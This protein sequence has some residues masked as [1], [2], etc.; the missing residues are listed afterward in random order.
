VVSDEQ[1]ELFSSGGD[2]DLETSPLLVPF[3]SFV[4]F[5]MQVHTTATFDITSPV[6]S[7]VAG[8][9]KSHLVALVMPQ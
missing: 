6:Y 1:Y 3:H 9:V 4:Y 8:N 2:F 5:Y 7:H